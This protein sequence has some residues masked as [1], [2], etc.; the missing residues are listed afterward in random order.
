MIQN[1]ITFGGHD[2]IV[3]TVN[4]QQMLLITEKIIGLGWYHSEFAEI[5]WADC[6]L[7]QYLN[8]EFY[9]SFCQ[10]EQE[11]IV[12]VVNSNHNNQW[13]GTSGGADTFDKVFF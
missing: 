10:T 11:R 4:E 2:W 5:T 13:F 9:G 8:S 1:K 7:R 12:G 3:L 6:T